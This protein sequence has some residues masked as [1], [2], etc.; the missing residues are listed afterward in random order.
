MSDDCLFWMNITG[1]K[2]SID[3][4]VQ[5]LNAQYNNSPNDPR[6]FWRVRSA[7]IQTM[8]EVKKGIYTSE[9]EG[10][11]AHSVYTAMCDGPNTYQADFP[12]G[13]GTTLKIESERL[14]LVIEITSDVGGEEGFQESMYFVFG[15]E[16]FSECI[17]N[18]E[19]WYDEYEFSSIADFNERYNLSATQEDLDHHDI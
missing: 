16:R 13:N 3:E 10:S 12:N 7:G 11:C 5:I 4:M 9:V 14:H 2:R 6:H 18:K 15:K 1:T 8:N 19:Y 17:S